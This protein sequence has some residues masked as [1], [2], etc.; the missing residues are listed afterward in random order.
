LIAQLQA[1]PKY[2][3]P[4]GDEKAAAGM[5]LWGERRY[6]QQMRAKEARWRR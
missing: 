3:R 1:M 2:R 4:I 6:L 5:R